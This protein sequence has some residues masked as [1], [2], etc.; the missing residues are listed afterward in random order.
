MLERLQRLRL[1]PRQ[2]LICR[3]QPGTYVG[4]YGNEL[5]R[6]ASGRTVALA[7]EADLYRTVLWLDRCHISIIGDQNWMTTPA[8]ALRRKSASVNPTASPVGRLTDPLARPALARFKTL[9]TS[10]NSVRRRPK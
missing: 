10:T 4:S 6:G 1:L 5:D 9:S 8:D 3:A 2:G 7:L